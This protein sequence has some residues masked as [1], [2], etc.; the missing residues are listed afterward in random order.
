VFGL[1]QLLGHRLK[2]TPEYAARA[3]LTAIGAVA[4]AVAGLSAISSFFTSSP[5][6]SQTAPAV[7]CG[8]PKDLISAEALSHIASRVAHGEPVKIVAFGSSSTAGTGATSATAA[9]PSQLQVALRTCSPIR[10][11]GP[12]QRR[13]WRAGATNGQTLPPRCAGEH[14][15]LLIWQTGTNSALAHSDLGDYVDG[16]AHGVD[17][18]APPASTSFS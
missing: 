4:L 12:E 5:A 17:K 8:V 6:R 3:A 11:H 9:Y 15:D 1:M 18:A 13:A 7:E 10:N 16:L 2:S 14:P